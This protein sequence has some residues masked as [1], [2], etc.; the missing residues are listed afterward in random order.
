MK[1]SRNG[2][3]ISGNRG[4]GKLVRILITVT[5]LYIAKKR[6]NKRSTVNDRS[7]VARKI[8]SW[9]CVSACTVRGTTANDPRRGVRYSIANEHTG[10]IFLWGSLINCLGAQEAAHCRVHCSRAFTTGEITETQSKRLFAI[11]MAEKREGFLSGRP[12]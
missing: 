3:I 5:I 11:L 7:Q 10:L 8:L 6:F 12:W 2:T 4:G 9:R 1:H